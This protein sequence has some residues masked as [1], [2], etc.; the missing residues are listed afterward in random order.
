MIE[1]EFGEV[2]PGDVAMVRVVYDTHEV[3]AMAQEYYQVAE[4]LAE[5]L[6]GLHAQFQRGKR[7]SPPKVWLLMITQACVCLFPRV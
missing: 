5:L 6:D 7:V 1:R 4:K 2:F 3:D